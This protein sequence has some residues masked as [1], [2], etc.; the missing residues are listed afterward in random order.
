M[1]RTILSIPEEEKSWLDNYGQRH[2]I[3]TAEVVRRAI[4]EFRRRKSEK[5]LAA[6]LGETAGTWTSPKGDSR[7]LVDALRKDWEDQT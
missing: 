7:D 4:R 2:R 5:G 6:V 3:S 1:T